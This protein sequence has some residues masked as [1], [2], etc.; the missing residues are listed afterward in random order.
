VCYVV[1]KT[2]LKLECTILTTLL[3]TS[4]KSTDSWHARKG[5]LQCDFPRDILMVY[6]SVLTVSTDGECLMCSASPSIKLFTLGAL[7]LLLTAS[8]T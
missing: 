8:T 1:G 5:D 3:F 6:S 2:T 4:A 7:S